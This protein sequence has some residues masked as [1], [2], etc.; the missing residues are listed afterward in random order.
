MLCIVYLVSMVTSVCVLQLL[1]RD[2]PNPL[3]SQSDLSVSG[4]T[5]FVEEESVERATRPV[6]IQCD[7]PWDNVTV[8]KKM[9]AIKL[10]HDWIWSMLSFMFV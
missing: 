4:R 10:Y 3:L 2:F 7:E 8:V 6:I 1:F 5:L 9:A